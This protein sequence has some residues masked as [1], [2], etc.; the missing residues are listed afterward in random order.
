MSSSNSRSINVSS[1]DGTDIAVTVTGNGPP[2]VISPG[3]LGDAQDW[4]L[5]ADALAPNLTTY[6]VDRRGRRRQR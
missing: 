4:Q 2:L 1:A 6:A 3:S 5:L